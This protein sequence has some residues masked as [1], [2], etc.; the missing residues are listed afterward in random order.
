[1]DLDEIIYT[2][3]T[4]YFKKRSIANDPLLA[5]RVLLEDIR[6]KLTIMA[7]ALTGKNIEIFAAE[8]EGGYR[9]NNFFLPLQMDIFA[10]KAENLKFYFFRLVY[11][12]IQQNM[13]LNWHVEENENTLHEARYEA[14]GCAT[15][16]LNLMSV[17]YPKVFDL[18]QQFYRHLVER[19]REE[20]TDLELF[21]LYGKWMRNHYADNQGKNM[22]HIPDAKATERQKTPP[23]TLLK[24]KAIEEIKS[25]QVDT[26]QQED[27]VLNHNFE[28]VET[29]EEFNG[30][31][32]DFDGDDQLLDHQDAIQEL[33]M[34]LTVRV[35]DPVHSVYQTEFLENSNVV[36]SI[37]LA[38][39]Q[40]HILYPEWDYNHRA[41]KP[42][43]CAVYPTF[44]KEKNAKYYEQTL[45][46]HGSILMS[47]R[48]MLTSYYNKRKQVKRQPDG[49]EFDIDAITD[50]Y[51]DVHAGKTPSDRIYVSTLKKEK[52]ISILLLLD[53]S[54][55]SDGYAAGNRVIDV[56][57]QVSL[58]F[59]E[60]LNE[61][62]VDFAV[63]D[64][65]SSTRNFLSF[66]MLKDFD[67]PWHS[68]KLKIGAAEPSGYTRIGGALRH[69]TH[70][71]KNRCSANKWV[72]LLSDG[73][74]NDYDKY[75]GRYGIQDIRQALREAQECEINSYA[76]AIEAQ[77]RYYL[78]QMFGQNHYQILASPVE[79]LSSMVRLFEKIHRN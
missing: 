45:S 68:G 32:R 4:K 37:D 71:L 60:I 7:R 73:K 41:Y 56:E 64:F 66:R 18:H 77:A 8:Q 54:L 65:H 2:Y 27:Y 26:K 15:D 23:S 36:E 38:E 69:A 61:F 78:P 34:K 42:N 52:D 14:A 33:S 30:T 79:L 21:W 58:L 3:F 70:L 67:E 1:M 44:A 43:F 75:E 62:Q 6:P 20:N 5:H 24:A 13:N 25:I 76:L 28:K 53:T 12:A 16:I 39:T 55:S 35:D 74:P 48:K 50:L 10:D 17:D 57:K 72:I 40:P 47:M 19:S 59:G 29:A 31:W 9:D 63:S 51:V 49:Q 22:Q 11:L 46:D